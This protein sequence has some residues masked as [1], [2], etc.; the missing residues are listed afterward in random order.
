MCSSSNSSRVP[1]RSVHGVPEDGELG[2]LGAHQAAGAVA[3]VD[4]NADGHRL[5][6]VRHGNLQAGRD[7]TAI[8]C[9]W[10]VQMAC[11]C[12]Y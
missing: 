3:G 6:V 12:T 10:S 5:T 11:G 1:G 4:A 7:R 2:Q 8:L 9:V